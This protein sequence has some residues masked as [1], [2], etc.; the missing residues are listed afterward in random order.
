MEES[1]EFLLKHTKRKYAFKR[2]L[3]KVNA[4][5]TG[6]RP[7]KYNSTAAWCKLGKKKINDKGNHIKNRKNSSRK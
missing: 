6:G 4:M 3:I 7:K 1:W 5:N 2:D